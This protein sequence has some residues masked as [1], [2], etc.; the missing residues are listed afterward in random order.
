MFRLF[1]VAC[2]RVYKVYMSFI[3]KRVFLLVG[4]KFNNKLCLCVKKIYL[5]LQWEGA[6]SFYP[7][8]CLGPAPD[9]RHGWICLVT[10]AR[11]NELEL[12]VVRL[13]T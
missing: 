9:S 5:I 1:I 11:E 10:L 4:I 3:F 2:T 13:C 8:F 6:H 12:V 7:L